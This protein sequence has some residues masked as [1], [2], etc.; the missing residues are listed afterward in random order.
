MLTGKSEVVEMFERAKGSS[1]LEV[2]RYTTIA[3]G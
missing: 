1:H 2:D 3:L